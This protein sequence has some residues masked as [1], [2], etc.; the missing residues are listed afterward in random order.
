MADHVQAY[1]ELCQDTY[2]PETRRMCVKLPSKAGLAL[3]LGIHRDTL[4]SWSLEYPEVREALER[5]EQEQMDR[6]INNSLG[7]NYNPTISKLLLMSNHG[8]KEKQEV[9][10]KMPLLSIVENIYK[11]ADRIYEE[12]YGPK[13]KY[14]P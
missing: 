13:K 6:L 1:L 7:G 11:E 3:Y 14:V 9:E 10:Q 2:N 12:Q 8:M 4:H 5:V